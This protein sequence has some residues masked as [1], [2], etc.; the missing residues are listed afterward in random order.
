MTTRRQVYGLTVDEY[1][2]M[3]AQAKGRCE[4]CQ[5]EPHKNLD[6]DRKTGKARGLVCV[7]CNARLR[8]VDAGRRTQT[9]DEARY[10]ALPQMGFHRSTP[11]RSL[12]INA[13]VW[14]AAV[15]KARAE[16]TTVT[17]VV[18]AAL[19]RYLKR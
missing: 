10:L 18:E 2:A 6:H 16:G 3:I 1:E 8:A 19:R 17:A 7:K 5:V 9:L 15:A 14:H 4:V 11:L 12:R 13:D